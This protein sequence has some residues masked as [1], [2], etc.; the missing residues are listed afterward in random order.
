MGLQDRLA[1]AALHLVYPPQCLTCD[2]QVTTDFALCPT[3]WRDTPFVTGLV[4]DLCGTPLPGQDPGHPVHC[5]DCLT[6]ARPWS[7]GRAAL[8]YR[9][10]ARALVLSLKHG[11][12]MD[13]AA[14]AARWMHRAAQPMIEPGMLVAPVPLHWMRLLRRRYN[15]SALLS[16]AFAQLAGL[17]HCPDLLQRGRRTP[18]QDG[19]DRDARFANLTGA[20]RVHPRRRAML[21]ERAVLLIDDVMTSGATLAAASEAC[22]AAGASRVVV[23]VLARVVKDG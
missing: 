3:C 11:D 14:P 8:I 22:L 1:Q 19:R 17:D 13:L 16:G 21:S 18:T 5:D 12:R 2:A 4:C 15:Q 20:L 23:V 9:D 7:R 6:M 10:N